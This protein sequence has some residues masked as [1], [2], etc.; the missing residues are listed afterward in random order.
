VRLVTYM[1]SMGL[2]PAAT[3]A[4]TQAYW[5][6]SNPLETENY[7]RKFQAQDIDWERCRNHGLA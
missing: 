5:C 7:M 3:G 4:A 6:K 2:D 1:A